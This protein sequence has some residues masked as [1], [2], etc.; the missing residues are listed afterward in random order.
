MNPLQQQFNAVFQE[1]FGREPSYSLEEARRI[2]GTGIPQLACK[3][4]LLGTK[5]YTEYAASPI[6]QEEV[7]KKESSH[8]FMAEQESISSLADIESLIRP[9]FSFLGSKSIQ[10]TEVF[11]SDNVYGSSKVFASNYISNSKN[12]GFSTLLNNCEYVFGS[13]NML[14]SSFCLRTQDSKLLTNCFEVSFSAKC[15]NSLFCHNSFDLRD[16]MFCFHLVSKQYCI[17][18]RQYSKEE[19]FRIKKMLI[20]ELV[21]NNFK[22]PFFPVL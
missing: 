14:S 6:S 21:K 5:V 2:F 1:L 3:T 11:E 13:K 20:D 9:F 19:Y 12:I 4:T 15:S 18:N 10:S 22:V 16:C 7:I 17:A 8:G